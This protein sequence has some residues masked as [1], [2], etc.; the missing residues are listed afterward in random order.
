MNRRRIVVAVLLVIV[1]SASAAL[2][3]AQVDS[4]TY[5]ACVNN[6]SGTIHMV[7]AGDTCTNNEELYSWSRGD[8]GYSPETYFNHNWFYN[9]WNY[10]SF[11]LGPDESGVFELSCDD[12]HEP[13]WDYVDGGYAK[14]S[15]DLEI[16]HAYPKTNGEYHVP[17]TGNGIK[18]VVGA[19]NYGDADTTLTIKVVC[20]KYLDEVPTP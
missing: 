13:G 14:D 8:F 12:G 3:L 15:R 16:F 10:E 20:G 7:E 18:F 4:E 1:L 5:Y 17:G 11:V 2:A 9:V 19:K 6:A